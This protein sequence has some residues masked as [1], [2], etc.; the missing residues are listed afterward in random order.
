MKGWWEIDI[1]KISQNSYLCP[2]RRRQVDFHLATASP[3]RDPCHWGQ[4]NK[5]PLLQW[6]CVSDLE[7]SFKEYVFKERY[8]CWKKN[9]KSKLC[10]LKYFQQQ[11]DKCAILMQRSLIQWLVSS[12]AILLLFSNPLRA[13]YVVDEFSPWWAEMLGSTY[14]RQ[15][16]VPWWWVEMPGDLPETREC[17]PMVSRD[18][19]FDLPETK[20]CSPMVSIDARLDPSPS[21]W[22]LA[23]AVSQLLL[24]SW[25]SLKQVYVDGS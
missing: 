16:T 5:T 4:S 20:E 3:W 12:T 7:Y 1:H 19:R 15:E 18:A 22:H 11:I 6:C 23:C 13:I 24:W 2:S 25:M 14:P 9:K 10:K 21:S 8:L 17:S